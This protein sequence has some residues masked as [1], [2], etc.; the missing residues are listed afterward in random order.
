MKEAT[1]GRRGPRKGDGG[2]PK[3]RFHADPD[4]F[5]L[6]LAMAVA[7]LDGDEEAALKFADMVLCEKPSVAIEPPDRPKGGHS[8]FSLLNN[9]GDVP[10]G[11]NSDSRRRLSAPN[12]SRLWRSRLATLKRKISE[13]RLEARD[14]DWIIGS[15]M[16]L[17]LALFKEGR[18]RAIG[19]EILRVHGWP[20][21]PALAGLARS[22]RETS[23]APFRRHTIILGSSIF[24]MTRA[25]EKPSTVLRVENAFRISPFIID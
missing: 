15:L 1:R 18:S 17:H 11:D 20:F 14:S 21:S 4:R 3:V 8:G 19:R 10:A 25:D 22:F 9:A 7:A 2:R 16:G 12:G 23:R 13:Y 24:E 5:V 6:T